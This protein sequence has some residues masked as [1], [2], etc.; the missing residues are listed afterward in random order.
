[1]ICSI[2]NQQFNNW[3]IKKKSFIVRSE[4]ESLEIKEKAIFKGKINFTSIFGMLINIIDREKD[5]SS[6]LMNI[7]MEK[8]KYILRVMNLKQIQLKTPFSACF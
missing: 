7:S 3:E 6:V 4:F 2:A 8:E 1:M 5:K